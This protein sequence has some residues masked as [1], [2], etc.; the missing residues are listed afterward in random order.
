MQTFFHE[1]AAPPKAVAKV[2]S[3]MSALQ[4]EHLS[5]TSWS[6]IGYCWGGKIVRLSAREGTPFKAAVQTSPALV[7][8]KGAS[9]VV[10][11]MAVLASKDENAEAI[12]E[13]VRI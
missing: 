3:V 8:P 6:A 13:W 10:I 1:V 11:P 2:G 12:K 7:D 4:S 9:E 5:I